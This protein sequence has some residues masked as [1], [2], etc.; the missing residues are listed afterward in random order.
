MRDHELRR[1]AVGEMNLRRWP[2]LPVPC[3]IVQWVLAIDDTERADELHAIE[4]KAGEADAV[5]NPSHRE[6]HV[7]D[8][9]TFTWERQSEG[10]SLTLYA[11]PCDEAGFL[12]PASDESI[13]HAIAWAQTLPGQVIRSTRIWLGESDAE[14]QRV[15][16]RH[17]L[18]IGR[19]HV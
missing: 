14:V 9:V 18:K 2:L 10:S 19:A 12:D 16:D 15:L 3:H 17:S 1:R 11:S 13:S 4:A 8:R 5:G 6:G 7:N